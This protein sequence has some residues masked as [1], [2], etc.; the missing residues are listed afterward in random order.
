MIVTLWP[1]M[2]IT[3]VLK[4]YK[5]GWGR[6][7]EESWERIEKKGW[8]DV[9]SLRS[10]VGALTRIVKIFIR[11]G[12][13]CSCQVV[14]RWAHL[15]QTQKGRI[16]KPKGWSL[17]SALVSGKCGL[18]Q[19]LKHS[20]PDLNTPSRYWG[21]PRKMVAALCGCW[22]VGTAIQPCWRAV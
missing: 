18:N 22:E 5:R 9:S 7:S 12:I 6:V 4:E 11:I 8:N 2:A 16:G 20:C 15:D 3:E 13:L 17:W 10:G 21:S 1:L 19:Q 14:E